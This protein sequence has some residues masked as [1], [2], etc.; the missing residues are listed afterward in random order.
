M[1]PIRQLE[2]GSDLIKSAFSGLNK[3]LAISSLI[4]V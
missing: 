4:V 2:I 3:S 1:L